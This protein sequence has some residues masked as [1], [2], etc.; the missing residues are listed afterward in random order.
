MEGQEQKQ[1]DEPKCQEDVS[2]F[3][4]LDEWRKVV[5]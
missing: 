2:Q 4:R 5:L 1:A 3:F